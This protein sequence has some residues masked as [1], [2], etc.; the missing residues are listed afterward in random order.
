M[1][2]LHDHHRAHI[3]RV[4]RGLLNNIAPSL[5]RL[6]LRRMW[7]RPFVLEYLGMIAAVDPAAT[8]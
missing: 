5:L 3:T 6:I 8:G 4:S 2:G 7:Q 1:I